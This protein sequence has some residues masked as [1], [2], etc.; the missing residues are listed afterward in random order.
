MKN[1]LKYGS[2]III[3]IIGLVT[4]FP[5]SNVNAAYAYSWMIGGEHVGRNGCFFRKTTCR[6]R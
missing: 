6:V 1:K 5:I 2:L 4:F 3:A